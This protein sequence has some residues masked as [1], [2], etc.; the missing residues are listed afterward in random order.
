[1]SVANFINNG[2]TLLW[3]ASYDAASYQVVLIKSD[4][5][6]D[7]DTLTDVSKANY[8][9]T[10]TIITGFSFQ[11]RFEN[12]VPKTKYVAYVRSLCDME[13]SAWGV[14]PFYMKAVKNVPYH[15]NFNMALTPGD[16]DRMKEW[17]YGNNTGNFV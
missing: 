2:V 11:C 1:M 13:N 3:Q 10:D 6:I 9:V 16:V 7:I 12:L 15:E 17:S 14:F 5:V 8:V 4:E